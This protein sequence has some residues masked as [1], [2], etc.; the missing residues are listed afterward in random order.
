MRNRGTLIFLVAIFLL[1]FSRA[2]VFAQSVIGM[3]VAGVQNQTPL[4]T[5]VKQPK[6]I[7]ASGAGT[8]TIASGSCSTLTCNSGDTCNCWQASVPVTP[9]GIGK[10]TLA[11]SLNNDTTPLVNNGSNGVCEPM[12]GT[13]TITKKNGDLANLQIGGTL[14]VV[15]GSVPPVMFTG[16]YTM[17]G[18]T[19]SLAAATGTGVF[20]F[21]DDSINL[22]SA[23]FI[24]TMTGAFSK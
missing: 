1:S 13:G 4:V 3:P 11:F 7:T 5:T 18:G 14:C 22:G 15:G 17:I 10:S 8:G 23:N 2:S 9:T 24:A 21:T 6:A 19:G 20:S 16:N 12:S